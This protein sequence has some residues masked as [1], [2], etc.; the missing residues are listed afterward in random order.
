MQNSLC[1]LWNRRHLHCLRLLCLC[2]RQLTMVYT[3]PPSRPSKLKPNRHSAQGLHTVD[4]SSA[5]GFSAQP[6]RRTARWPGKSLGAGETC[7]FRWYFHFFS[8]IW[9][10]DNSAADNL[11]CKAMSYSI[12]LFFFSYFPF[13]RLLV[14]FPGCRYR[15]RVLI[16]ATFYDPFETKLWVG[17][18]TWVGLYSTVIARLF[19]LF[20]P[21]LNLVESP[22]N[23]LFVG[24]NRELT[25]KHSS[26]PSL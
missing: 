18:S 20:N 19:V 26:C 12:W 9:L 11:V 8:H 7:R 5:V 10:V 15:F 4:G 22:R 2:A 6:P 13:E 16:L 25:F 21:P 3:F 17:R 14:P 1:I 24:V 23:V